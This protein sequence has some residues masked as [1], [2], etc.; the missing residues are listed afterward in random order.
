MT[1]P[2]EELKA[3]T[4]AL[5]PHPRAD[6]VPPLSEGEYQALRDDIKAR[7]IQ[8]PLVVRGEASLVILCGHQRLRAALELSLG[9]VPVTVASLNGTS[10]EEYII[11][12]NL[13]RRQLSSYH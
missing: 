5:R 4:R 7:G 11:L 12:D 6:L 9:E 3:Q 2:R 1:R 10:E 8:V 13:R